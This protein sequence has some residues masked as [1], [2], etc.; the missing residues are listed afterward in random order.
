EAADAL[1][2]GCE[3]RVIRLA[4]QSRRVEPISEVTTLLKFRRA[5][6]RFGHVDSITTRSAGRAVVESAHPTGKARR[7]RFTTKEIE[8]V[9]AHEEFRRVQQIHMIV[10]GRRGE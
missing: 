8:I 10:V 6:E 4:S 2:I 3:L 7:V 9:L 1:K 5:I